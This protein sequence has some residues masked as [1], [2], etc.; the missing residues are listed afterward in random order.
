MFFNAT[1]TTAIY[2]YGH[3]LSEHDALPISAFDGALDGVQQFGGDDE[4]FSLDPRLAG[5]STTELS[6]DLLFLDLRA[7]LS[8]QLLNSR[9]SSSASGASTANRDFL[10]TMTASPYL[11]QRIGDFADAEW[12]YSLDR[13][14]T[15]LNS[16]H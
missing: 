1:P 14:S 7:A 6:D 4:G 15:R 11:V 2:T 3:T 16:S 10:V 13:K 12:R 8:R 9:D 5:T